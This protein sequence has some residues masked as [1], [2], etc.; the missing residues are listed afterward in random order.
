MRG[1]LMLVV[2][3]LGAPTLTA[4]GR[5]HLGVRFQIAHLECPSCVNPR[6]PMPPFKALGRKRLRELAVFL[7]A[8]KGLH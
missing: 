2:R 5:R 6:P 7:E 8:S 3:N 4:I 1:L